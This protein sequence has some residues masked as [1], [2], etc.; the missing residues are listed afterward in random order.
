M[1]LVRLRL[2]RPTAWGSAAQDWSA[3]ADR[4]RYIFVYFRSRQ[5]DATLFQPPFTAEQTEAILA[6]RVPA[7][8][9]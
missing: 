2:R 8:E 1:L 9:L 5:R 3:L 7:G 4:M 6:G